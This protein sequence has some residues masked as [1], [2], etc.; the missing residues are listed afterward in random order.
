[1]WKPM[2]PPLR[3]CGLVQ[4]GRPDTFV[5]NRLS[6]LLAKL[7]APGPGAQGGIDAHREKVA[8]K[9]Q[10]DPP[11]GFSQELMRCR[12]WRTS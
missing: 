1:M 7:R 3:W 8:A 12:A 6:P 10:R 2:R 9:L 4:Q 11:H 5:L